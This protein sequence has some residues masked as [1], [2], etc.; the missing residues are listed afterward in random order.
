MSSSTTLLA[1]KRRYTAANKQQVVVA[2]KSNKSIAAADEIPDEDEDEGNNGASGGGDLEHWQRYAVER[3]IDKHEN[4]FITGQAGTGKSFVIGEILRRAAALGIEIALTATTGL[5]AANLEP[6]APSSRVTPQTIHRWAG[7]GL[8]QESVGELVARIRQNS[9][10]LRRWQSKRLLLV[11]DEISMMSPTLLRKLDQIARLLRQ[12]PKIPFG[13]IQ[14][15]FVGDFYQLPPV[16]K[17]GS[18]EQHDCDRD[19][20][21]YE[22]CF[23]TP[24]WTDA[25]DEEILLQRIFR[26]TDERFIDVLREVRDGRLGQQSIALLK[27]RSYESLFYELLALQKQ[28]RRLLKEKKKDTDEEE[29]KDKERGEDDDEENNNSVETGLLRAMLNEAGMEIPKHLRV[30]LGSVEP[31]KLMTVNRIVDEENSRRMA[32]LTGASMMYEAFFD[33]N[34]RLV[35]NKDEQRVDM[36]AKEMK[37]SVTAPEFLE[38]KVGAQVLLLANLDDTLV[39]GR[40]GYV[41]DFVSDRQ[42]ADAEGGA[43]GGEEEDE[44]E[45]FKDNDERIKKAISDN[46]RPGERLPGFSTKSGSSSNGKKKKKRGNEPDQEAVA[47]VGLSTAVKNDGTA[48]WP[49]VEFDNGCKQAIKPY[50][51]ER[52]NTQF[53]WKASITQI[54]LKPAYAMS[55]HKSQSQTLSSV[56]IDLTS[57]FAAGMAYSA[58]S[59]ATSLEGLVLENFDESFFTAQPPNWKV[60]HYYRQLATEQQQKQQKQQQKN[61]Q[62]DKKEVGEKEVGGMAAT[63]APSAASSSTSKKK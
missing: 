49:L 11:I 52:K 57:V 44:E 10:T 19:G 29:E 59:R 58:V 61:L 17:S 22:Y 21:P 53:K 51:W 46:H 33:H 27:Q 3:V 20:V 13:G 42:I 31:T 55:I 63:S 56:A 16:L 50:K 15:V 54:P 34:V 30:L 35:D 24:T 60:V 8:G 43:G 38:L 48:L 62:K 40:R 41:V 47:A 32:E 9:F 12:S 25:I 7:I 2:K 14:L 36:I 39:N 6:I 5:A 1:K 26:Q 18:D 45:S 28:V 23:E 37:T 4:V